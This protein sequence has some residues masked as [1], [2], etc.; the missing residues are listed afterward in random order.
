MIIKV[1]SNENVCPSQELAVSFIQL[2][3]YDKLIK[4]GLV[5]NL[6]YGA[7]FSK[8]N[9][10]RYLNAMNDFGIFGKGAPDDCITKN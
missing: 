5:N 7:Y 10:K 1:K 2:D 6:W 9:I 4:M 8:Y 3:E